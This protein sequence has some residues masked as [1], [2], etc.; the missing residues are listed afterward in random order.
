M[1]ILLLFY[2]W[3]NMLPVLKMHHYI[4]TVN[5]KP[6]CIIMKF[7]IYPMTDPWCWYIYIYA[8]MT[9]VY[10]WDPWHTIYSSTVR[11]RHGYMDRYTN[12]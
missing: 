5:R 3:V 8:N 6:R 12:K 11:I 9:G 4:S 10:S 2:G 7:I 1:I